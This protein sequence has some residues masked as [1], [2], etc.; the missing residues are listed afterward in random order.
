MHFITWLGYR[1]LFNSVYP[2]R[3]ARKWEPKVVVGV[4][5]VRTG[6]ELSCFSYPR[7]VFVGDFIT[8]NM[9]L[10][11]SFVIEVFSIERDL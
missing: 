3:Q 1:A 2:T 5:T 11:T 9:W 10:V 8:V 7:N 4:P 6:D